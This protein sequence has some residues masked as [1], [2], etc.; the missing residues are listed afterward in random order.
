MKRKELDFVLIHNHYLEGGTKEACVKVRDFLHHATN[1]GNQIH[2]ELSCVTT[3]EFMEAVKTLMAFAFQED[4]SIP[5]RWK[6]DSDCRMDSSI[7][8]P[9]ECNIS[10][11][12]DKMCPFFM[13]EGLI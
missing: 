5:I 8:C 12:A 11:T 4:D 1:S 7:F 2:S 9:G 13:D 10:K 3:N 6:C